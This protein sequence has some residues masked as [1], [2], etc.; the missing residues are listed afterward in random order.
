MVFSVCSTESLV[1]RVTID[2]RALIADRR[3]LELGPGL[4]PISDC[5]FGKDKDNVLEI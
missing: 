4:K 5:R 1:G 2:L 3:V